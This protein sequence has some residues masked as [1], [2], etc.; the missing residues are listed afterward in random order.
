M[1]GEAEII[2]DEEN[3]QLTRSTV[4]DEKLA[5]LSKKLWFNE[6]TAIISLPGFRVYRPENQ[7]DSV[8][9]GWYEEKLMK[10]LRPG[11]HAWCI[12]W[13]LWV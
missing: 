8:K 3:Q 10:E 4:Y 1:Y 9:Y 11:W 2:D 5:E 6:S 7:M 12:T 13:R